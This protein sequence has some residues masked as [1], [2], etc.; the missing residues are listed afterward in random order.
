ME[1]REL[2]AYK[3]TEQSAPHSAQSNHTFPLPNEVARVL[4]ADPARQVELAQGIIHGA[5][6]QAAAQMAGELQHLR[7]AVADKDSHIRSLED[8]LA[9]SQDSLQDARSQLQAS[10]EQCESLESKRA[11]LANALHKLEAFQR[12]I[13]NTLQASDQAGED[14]GVLPPATRGVRERST[15]R[16]DREDGTANGGPLEGHKQAFKLH[17]NSSLQPS[18]I[19]PESLRKGP[20]HQSDWPCR[21][22]KED[23]RLFPLEGCSSPHERPD[24]ALRP[25]G[26]SPHRCVSPMRE[27]S[28]TGGVTAQRLA[29][30]ATVRRASHDGTYQTPD[31]PGQLSGI[32]AQYAAGRPYDA[33]DIA[34]QGRPNE[35]LYSPHGG[36]SSPLDIPSD[37]QTEEPSR[38]Y[39]REPKHLQPLPNGQGHAPPLYHQDAEG[40]LA[41]PISHARDRGYQA[42]RSH[43][44]ECGGSQSPLQYGKPN[45]RPRSRGDHSRSGPG[46]P[47]SLGSSNRSE[48]RE[49]FRRARA[50][51]SN[52]AF[53]IFLQAIKDM[54]AGLRGRS[55]TLQT[56]ANVF[57]GPDGDLYH[58]FRALLDSH[59]PSR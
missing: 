16:D 33:A 7:A 32:A 24:Q 13:L 22:H 6:R 48:G 27:R 47:E 58:D 59:L 14:A 51:L 57:V 55:E 37:M 44:A 19:Q 39:A 50:R 12:N 2:H 4:P 49:F 18:H 52:E 53:S 10:Q 11:S 46:A 21:A 26:I 36:Y 28:A 9:A 56:A 38:N 34:A 23:S 54:N 20:G 40:R 43:T 5:F 3:P 30:T 45:G 17:E 15:Q 42:L 31:N 41:G 25:P 1:W 35:R 29:E 8:G